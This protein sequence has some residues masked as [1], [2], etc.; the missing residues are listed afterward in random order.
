M[1]LQELILLAVKL[2]I[3]LTVFAIGLNSSIAA[4][5][6]LFR[7]PPKL[8]KS[9]FAIDV[10]MPLFAL[11]LVAVATSLPQP[12]KVALVALSVAP[13]PPI[14]PKK[15]SSAGVAGDHS[16]GL[17]FAVALIAVVFVPLAVAFISP[18]FGG[19]THV[20]LWTV[21][22]LMLSTVLAPLAAGVAL[23]AVWPLFAARIAGP[24]GK[25]AGILLI[26]A[27]LPILFVAVPQAL[28][29]AHDGSI[30]AFALFVLVGLAVGHL[31]GGPDPDDRAVLAIATSTRHPGLAMAIATAALSDQKLAL[32]A[33]ALYLLVNI[34]VGAPYV[35]WRKR[36]RPAKSKRSPAE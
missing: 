28:S 16:V 3:V 20:P 18:L 2:S 19:N 22:S 21:A 25:F 33:V 26:A 23:R 12:V 24:L 30:A 10:V 9:L 1:T 7:D 35:I 11:A 14:F 13:A 31:L 17:L 36:L 15:T 5:T 29:L 6:T 8:A 32:A 34:V 27:V 4:L